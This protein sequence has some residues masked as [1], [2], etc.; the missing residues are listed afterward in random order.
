MLKGREGRRIRQREGSNCNGVSVECPHLL[1]VVL[2]LER[3]IIVVSSGDKR[4]RFL[5]RHDN[6]L[7]DMGR[8]TPLQPGNHHRDWHFRAFCLH[9]YQQKKKKSFIPKM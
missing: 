7:L 2:K 3:F 4:A 8:S 1:Q 9:H 5:D 6:Q